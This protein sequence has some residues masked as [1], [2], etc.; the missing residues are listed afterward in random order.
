MLPLSTKKEKKDDF[1]DRLVDPGARAAA[2]F[3]PDPNVSLVRRG[4]GGTLHPW[5][6]T[7]R[8][9]FR[10]RPGLAPSLL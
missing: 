9:Q 2:G 3:C 4:A 1:M 7:R 10:P 5:R 6:F 8:H